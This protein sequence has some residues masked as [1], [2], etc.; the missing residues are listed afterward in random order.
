MAAAL[1][2]IVR[3]DPK[4]KL[5]KISR[6]SALHFVSA[7]DKDLIKKMKSLLSEQY[8]PR[9]IGSSSAGNSHAN[10]QKWAKIKLVQDFMPVLV[11]Y[12]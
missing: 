7:S 10:R 1:M 9:S 3:S 11:I 5:S 4:S 2:I 12:V 6:L 8:F